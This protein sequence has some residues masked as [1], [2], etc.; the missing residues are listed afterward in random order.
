MTEAFRD[1]NNIE[2][3]LELLDSLW[4]FFLKY[5]IALSTQFNTFNL[6]ADIEWRL[7]N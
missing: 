7:V 1:A 3:G 2:G 5:N 4:H 6:K